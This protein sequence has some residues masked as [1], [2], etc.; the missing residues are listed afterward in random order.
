M[1]PFWV[2]IHL[3]FKSHYP[4]V[5]TYL[6]IWFMERA[7]LC[8]QWR[9]GLL[10]LRKTSVSIYFRRSGCQIQNRFLRVIYIDTSLKGWVQWR[11]QLESFYT[12]REWKR[13]SSFLLVCGRSKSCYRVFWKQEESN[14]KRNFFFQCYKVIR[15]ISSSN[16]SYG[17]WRRCASNLSLLSI[18]INI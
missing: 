7:G 4:T 8:P 13:E 10:L 5:V 11:I 18:P 2:G 9:N 14:T 1:R 17:I 16:Y 12:K 6:F 15:F 3:L